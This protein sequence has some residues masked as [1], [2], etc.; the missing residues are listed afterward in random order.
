MKGT[1][2][3]RKTY[4][5]KFQKKRKT[6]KKRRYRRKT[7]K[8]KL[9]GGV[10]INLTGNDDSP[11]NIQICANLANEITDITKPIE[12]LFTKVGFNEDDDDPEPPT[13]L[14]LQNAFKEY[15]KD[16]ISEGLIQGLSNDLIDR[17]QIKIYTVDRKNAILGKL[18]YT[19][20]Q[21]NKEGENFLEENTAYLILNKS[22]DED[23]IKASLTDPVQGNMFGMT[24][25][26]IRA[27]NYRSRDPA[28]VGV[29]G[30]DYRGYE[31]EDAEELAQKQL[32]NRLDEKIQSLN[33]AL[34]KLPKDNTRSREIVNS[35]LDNLK[36]KRKLEVQKLKENSPVISR[37]PSSISTDE[38]RAE[39]IQPIPASVMGV[40]TPAEETEPVSVQASNIEGNGPA[41]E[42]SDDR[43]AAEYEPGPTPD[44]IRGWMY[45]DSISGI[46]EEPPPKE[47]IDLPEENESRD[48]RKAEDNKGPPTKKQKRKKG[49]RKTS[50]RVKNRK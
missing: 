13:F 19:T 8:R 49:G 12:N 35:L 43:A 39:E 20:G 28:S 11:Q 22:D 33:E 36:G 2:K 17:I 14:Q 16:A 26:N 44:Q 3:K 21:E 23:K 29:R 6:S 15:L 42:K 24:I 9:I 18:V 5:N 7:L 25:S 45:W 50:H 27:Q 31:K 4:K 47:F 30:Y 41:E 10:N 1:K 32:I 40:V 46:P 37:E 38:Q 48:K 34:A